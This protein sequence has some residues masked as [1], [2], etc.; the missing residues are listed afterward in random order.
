MNLPGL[1]PGRMNREQAALVYVFQYLIGNTDWSFVLADGDDACCHNG[2]LIE[3]GG[4]IYYV[5]YDFDLSGLV[6]APYAKPA[7]ELN[8]PSVRMRRYRG[9]CEERETV[10]EALRQVK[11]LEPQVLKIARE[12]PG[13]GE[14]HRKKAGDYLAR[15]F[16]KA[17]NEEKLLKS[18]ERRCV[19]PRTASIAG[20]SPGREPG[21]AFTFVTR[22]GH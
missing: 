4:E 2:D 10:L 18:F 9:F 13:L 20:S 6:N 15:F 16:D 22:P 5:P 12:A 3:I 8:I 7:R 14:K 17:R 19:K 11:A 21:G 1:A